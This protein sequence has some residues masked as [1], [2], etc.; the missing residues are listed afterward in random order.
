MH[1][2]KQQ[3]GKVEGR[4]VRHL[5]ESP[6]SLKLMLFSLEVY[7]ICNVVLICAVQQSD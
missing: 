2:F 7:F 3:C 1:D 4:R 5:L 6:L